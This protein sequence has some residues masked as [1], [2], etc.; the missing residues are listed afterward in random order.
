MKLYKYRL[1]NF[2]APLHIQG[3]GRVY[4][5]E[6]PEVN[7]SVTYQPKEPMGDFITYDYIVPPRGNIKDKDRKD[8][9]IYSLRD[10]GD[11][12]NI[13]YTT[14]TS[15]SLWWENGYNEQETISALFV[16]STDIGNDPIKIPFYFAGVANKVEL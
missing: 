14:V 12:L 5:Y 11:T 3:T 15:S 9:V 1:N 10:F 13:Y 4:K 6:T 2:K 7:G 8:I 16:S